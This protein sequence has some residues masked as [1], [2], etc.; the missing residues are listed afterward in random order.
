MKGVAIIAGAGL[1]VAVASLVT[2][3]GGCTFPN[4]IDATPDGDDGADPGLPDGGE[5]S[6]APSEE[7][8]TTDD[9][10]EEVASGDAPPMESGATEAGDPCDVDG[11]GYRDVKCSLGTDCCDTDPR[12]HPL[13]SGYFATR[14]ACES[15]DYDCSGA[16]EPEYG[17]LLYCVGS[18]VGC[19]AWCPSSQCTCAAAVCGYGFTGPDPGCGN[20]GP[21]GTCTSSDGVCMAETSTTEL[22]QCH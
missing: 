21:W 13:Q 9:A 15:F 14:D 20:T 4:L 2:L 12:A 16:V 1:T 5:A 10:P 22:Q 18:L 6:T 19:V 17:A 8:D 3:G 11:D 7:S